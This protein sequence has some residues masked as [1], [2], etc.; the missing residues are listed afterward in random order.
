MSKNIILFGPPGAGKG[1]Q[2]DILTGEY[3]IP[4]LSTG[5]M[6]RE[7]VANQ[8]ELGRK[9]EKI[10]KEGGLVSDDIIV[11]MIS[12]RISRDDCAEGFLLDGFPRTVAQAEALE[13]MLDEKGRKVNFVIEIAVPDEELKARSEKRKQQALD[14]GQE[15]R[16]D[17]N[18]EIF[19]KRLATYWEQT[20]PVLPF[21]KERNLHSH[22]DGTQAID[23]VT[24]AIRNILS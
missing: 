24:K 5:D 12:E 19:T 6:L 15:P 9:A 20:A 18:P 8:T 16:A 10:M 11:G 17:D 22:I 23:S 1:T 4:K 13:K 3:K 2:A 21:Y 14:A 7:A